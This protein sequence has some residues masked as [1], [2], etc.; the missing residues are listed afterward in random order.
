MEI[1]IALDLRCS[2]PSVGVGQ[3]LIEENDPTLPGIVLADTVGVRA[4]GILPRTREAS[5]APHATLVIDN[6]V[7]GLA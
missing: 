2:V 6:Q 4:G 5:I 1:E 7:L 3:S